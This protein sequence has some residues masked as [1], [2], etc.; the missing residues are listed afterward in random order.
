MAADVF[1]PADDEAA[2]AADEAAEAAPVDAPVV[3]D[4]T[5]SVVP[6]PPPAA[7]AEAVPV[8]P[9][10]VPEPAATPGL[11]TP[12]FGLTHVQLVWDGANLS[13]IDANDKIL[14]HIDWHKDV[15]A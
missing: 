3:A 9:A 10:P 5:A 12:L 4:P 7:T 15:F 2:E 14:G 1:P 11:G 13:F 6:D 8:V